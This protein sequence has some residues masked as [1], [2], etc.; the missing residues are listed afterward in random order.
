MAYETK[1]L[2]NIIHTK[3]TTYT[4]ILV[5]PRFL[6]YLSDNQFIDVLSGFVH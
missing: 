5:N 2:G 1:Y 6:H 4:G 3:S